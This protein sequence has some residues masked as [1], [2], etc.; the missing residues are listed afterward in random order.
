MKVEK[1]KNFLIRFAYLALVL[2]L[3]YIV[4]KY[5]VPEVLPLILALFVALL[6]KGPI[7][8]ISE[9]KKKKR[10]LVSIIALLIFYAIV[11]VVIGL[12]GS[13]LFSLI[14]DIINALPDFYSGTVEP[15]LVDIAEHILIVFP[16]I[17][18]D[19]QGLIDYIT[20]WV[21]SFITN[22]SNS[23]VSVAG[24]VVAK[25]PSIITNVIF[26]IIASFFFTIYYHDITNF[27]FR[28]IP[29]DK[30]VE[31]RLLKGNV[32]GT[33][34]KYIK[35][36]AI[37]MGITFCELSIGM[38]LLGVSNPLAVAAITALVDI[39]P[40]L[41][42][43]TILIPWGIIALF[44][45]DFKTGLGMVILYVVITVVR[46]SVEPKVVGKQIGLHPVLT[47]VCVFIGGKLFGLLGVFLLPIT[48]AVIKQLHDDGKLHWFK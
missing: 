19:V 29:E 48:A 13:Q 43:G 20:N 41:G 5:I 12:L 7:D 6:L 26:M 3:V 32:V 42:T 11:V 39:L 9:S 35:S 18:S 15:F 30:A 31:S 14:K 10:S 37:L 1:Q 47:L 2:G 25:V 40:V 38:I 17:E 45:G 34:L 27:I 44:S 22:T 23:I 21:T 28:Q 8:K 46:Q 36:Y 16:E 4:I 24:N 33:I